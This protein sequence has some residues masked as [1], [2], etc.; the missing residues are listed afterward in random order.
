MVNNKKYL[1][2]ASIIAS[3]LEDFKRR[4]ISAESTLVLCDL[5]LKELEDRK[6]KTAVVLPT[7]KNLSVF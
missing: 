2:D 4:F 5:T 6:K 7:Q 1:I 3:S